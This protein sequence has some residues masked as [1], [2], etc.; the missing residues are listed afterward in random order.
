VSVLL[1][2]LITALGEAG[3]LNENETEG[4]QIVL[5]EIQEHVHAMFPD[6]EML[7]TRLNTAVSSLHSEN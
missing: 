5:I 4:A 6:A 2:Y 3:S 1:D 7:E